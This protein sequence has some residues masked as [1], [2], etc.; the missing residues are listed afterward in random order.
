MT[1]TL[2]YNSGSST[3]TLTTHPWTSYTFNSSGQL[4][5]VAD[6]D[7]ATA[8]L[9]YDSPSPGSG[10]C[11]ASA[12]SCETV[13]SASGRT[14]T[15][16]WS[17]SGDSGTITSVTD[18]LGRRTTYSYSSGNLVS[19]T[20][21]STDRVTSYTYDSS[22]ENADLQHDLLTVTEPNAQ[23]GGPDAGDVL[24]NAYNSSGRVTSQTD[25]MGGVTSFTYSSMNAST[26]DGEV[27]VVDPDGNE[28]KYVYEGNVLL[29]R[30]AGY[31]STNSTTQYLDNTLLLRADVIDPN[32]NTT[33]YTYDAD[34][35]TLTKTNTLGNTWSYSYNDFDEQTCA[36]LP[37]A[38]NPC[39]SLSPPSPISVGGSITAPSA[40]PA[41]VTYT[42][43]DT[44]G[45]KIYT[46]TGDYVSGSLVQT[47]TSY[48]LYNGNSVTVDSDDD[49]CTTSAPS[50]EL[51][52]ATIDPNGVVTQLTYDSAGD[53]TSSSTPDGNS[54]GQVAKTTYTYD[55]D[56][57][58]TST[59]APDGNVSGA[60][61]GNYT[62]TDAYDAD[63]EVT[64]STVGGGSGHTVVPRVTSYTY[65]GDGNVTATTRSTSPELI[66]TSS[67]HNSSSSLTLSLP[68]GTKTGDE[69]VL[70]TTTSP[71]STAPPLPTMTAD[72][73]YT[74]AGTGSSGATG[75][76]GQATDAKFG[77]P[78]RTVVDSAGNVYIAD[79]NE[80]R[81]QFLAASDCSSSCPWGLAST[82]AGDMYTIAGS[83]SGTSGHTGDSGAAT[84]ALLDGPEGVA[85]DASGNLYI[86][87]S[88]NNRIQFVAKSSCS[89]SCPWGLAST[90]ANDIYTIA[91]SSAGT[92]GHT[93]DSGAATSALLDDPGQIAL[94]SS[95]NL[96]VADVTNNRIQFVA[97]STCSSSCPWGLASTTAND[98]YTIAGSSTGSSGDTGD[99][100]AAASALLSSP[101]GV[102]FDSSGNLVIADSSNNRIQF[103]AASTCSSSC[104]W[105]LASTTANDIYTIAGSSS[106]SSGHT[107]DSGAATSALLEFPSTIVADSSGD[108]LFA[109]ESN[110]RVQFVAASACSSSCPWGLAS[111]TA[112]DIYTIAGSST[113]SGGFSGDGGVAT[114]ALLSGSDTVSL[115]GSGDL[116]ISD[117]SNDRLREVPN[118][119]KP[120]FTL[121]AHDIFTVAGTGSTGTS[122]DSGQAIDAPISSAGRA[123]VDS[124][125]NLYIDDY[126]NNRVQEVAA[127]THSQWG[128]SMVAGDVYTIAGSSS[129]SSGHTGDGGAATSAKLSG[130]DG[131]ALDSSGN[132]YIADYTNNRI[133]FLAA[134]SC[135]SS[136]PWGLA[137]T[138]ANDIYT[139][140]GSSSGT[141]GHT[142]DGGAATSALLDGPGQLAFDASGNLYIADT[143]NHRI[144]FLAA[145]SC[146]SSCPWGLASTTANDIYT[147]A[148]S[149][150]GTSGH[151]GDGGAATSALLDAPEGV[152]LDASGNLVIADSSNNRI[153]LIAKSTCASSCAWGL[154][155]TTAN[156]IYT[157]AG[158]STGSSGHTGDSGAA[159][160]ALLDFPA[161]VTFDSSGNLLIADEGN[162]RDQFVAAASCSSSCPWG[163]ASTTANDIYTIVGSSSGSNGS[164]GDGGPATSA[165]LSGPV[166]VALDSAGDLFVSDSSNNR[167]QEVPVA[168][169]SGSET[170][171]TPSGYT[172]QATKSTGSTT[173]YVYTHLVGSGDTGVTLNYSSSAPKAAVLAVYRGINTTSPIDVS[174]SG[175]TSPGTSV[176]AS[177]VTTTDDGDELVFVGGSGQQSS[178]NT[179]T[180]PSGMTT[181][182]SDSGITGLSTMLADETGP[183]AAGSTGSE[184][185]TASAA[186][187][188]TAIL[189]ALSPGT[190][191]SSTAFNADDEPTLATDSGRQRDPLLLR[192]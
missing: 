71:A 21:P 175:S 41:Y 148:G 49:S 153:Q 51:P 6:P 172:L 132:L 24:T 150:S 128:I 2:V 47:R 22:N 73:I 183:A 86:A 32:G 157:I 25:P 136:C 9:T 38:A 171:T 46:T 92:S 146:S 11:P 130:P 170:V 82:T 8:S 163:L 152:G 104:P 155:S 164:S 55:S 141:S 17:G 124:S 83:S 37:L 62:T 190:V 1:A 126:S 151:T 173:T 167:I 15:F 26:G 114:S 135:S 79:E 133:Q 189:L 168:G 162:D 176:S 60:N 188:L 123:I 65:D 112:N 118:T 34:G 100:G 67:S 108:L 105:G 10:N 102:G 159:T 117:S 115:D 165:L 89:S 106:G 59:V 192:R 91:G 70:S 48:D 143:Y 96:Y 184:S 187:Q 72:D 57:E 109:D 144:Q 56:G 138:T 98:I 81:I 160:S 119:A 76:A 182:A 110:S 43:Y 74:I 111:T 186:G 88:S 131:L 78:T 127:T 97:S 50:T 7:G 61:A 13:T 54:G 185:A 84:S 177:S 139:I 181:E 19:E 90:T 45:N 35:N 16:G 4:S 77:R 95:G 85:L 52:C 179:W 134:S 23:S 30:V 42:E 154:S 5:S 113:G 58:R 28:S 31:G 29:E 122:G 12:G 87:D 27:F 75:D 33:S 3:Y 121:T 174:S 156:D 44:D 149:S 125:G 80:N 14:L 137:S 140:A 191:T 20:D 99:S 145:A 129:G 36:A 18:P 166:G 180:A 107:G 40:P 64:S 142:G 103:V 68:P 69:V 39:S 161:T 63:G 169:S 53:V 158:S 66:G 116:F 94:D 101:E 93:G 178:T 147:I 120:P